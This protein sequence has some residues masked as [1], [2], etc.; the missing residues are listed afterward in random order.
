M[1]NQLLGF[2]AILLTL[3]HWQGKPDVAT[4]GVVFR[5][6]NYA[7]TISAPAG[8]VVDT[9]R[10]K[11]LYGLKAGIYPSDKKAEEF[12][13]ILM[14]VAS[15]QKEGKETLKN[16]LAL[17][18]TGSDSLA[19]MI[20]IRDFAKTKDGKLVLARRFD[21]ADKTRIGAYVDDEQ[22]V[23]LLAMSDVKADRRER[24][25]AALKDLL[26]SYST[27]KPN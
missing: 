13:S 15:K 9:T 20:E 10:W 27:M 8:W 14:L 4:G 17:W 21:T 2:L 1:V 5:G 12:P 16:L 24:V 11:D 3:T 6:D 22:I 25:V 18:R 7:F 23:V 19:K 26:G